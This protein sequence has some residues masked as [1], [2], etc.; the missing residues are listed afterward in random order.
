MPGSVQVP[1]NHQLRFL[2]EFVQTK[3]SV[4]FSEAGF[5]LHSTVQALIKAKQDVAYCQLSFLTPQSAARSA[6]ALSRA[7]WY[8]AFIWPT[9]CL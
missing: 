1:G 8:W 9:F 7:S 2:E 5:S 3:H 4:W 6:L